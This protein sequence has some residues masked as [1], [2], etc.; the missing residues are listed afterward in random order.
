MINVTNSRESKYQ[1]VV[2]HITY[3]KISKY[4]HSEPNFE[5]QYYVVLGC[6]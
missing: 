5:Y 4:L 3:G 2:K 1:R 6:F